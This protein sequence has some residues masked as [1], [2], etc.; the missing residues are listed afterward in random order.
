[1][2]AMSFYEQLLYNGMCYQHA[3]RFRIKYNRSSDPRVSSERYGIIA[4][5]LD[6]LK[7]VVLTMGLKCLFCN[8]VWYLASVLCGFK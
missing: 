2:E 5:I 8:S 3:C 7:A 4:A 1:M 6:R